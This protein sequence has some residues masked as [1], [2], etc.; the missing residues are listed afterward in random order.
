MIKKQYQLLSFFFFFL[1]LAI[2]ALK[3]QKSI[4]APLETRSVIKIAL[5]DDPLTLDPRKNSDGPTSCFLSFLSEGL[6]KRDERGELTLSLAESVSISPDFKEYIFTLKEA[7]WSNGEPISSFQIL[8]SWKEALDQ[9][10]KAYNPEYFFGIKNARAFFEGKVEFD[11]VGIK[12]PSS[13]KFEV[14]LEEPDPHFLDLLTHRSFYPIYKDENQYFFKE[15]FVCSGPFKIEKWSPKNIITLSK[16][17]LYFDAASVRLDQIECHIVPHEHTQMSLFQTKELDW[18]GSPFS[19]LILDVHDQI[20]WGKQIHKVGSFSL[21]FFAFNQEVFPLQHLKIRKALAL[22]IDRKELADHLFQGKE[23]PALRILPLKMI[24]NDE[25]KIQDGDV[26][27]AKELF[28]QGLTELKLTRKTFPKISLSYSSSQSKHLLAQ[29]IQQ[30]WQKILGVDI[31]LQPQENQMF[32]QAFYKRN[33][34][35]AA[36]S[37]STFQKNP[38]FFLSFFKTSTALGKSLSWR[39]ESFDDLLNLASLTIHPSSREIILEKAEEFLISEMPI[40]PLFFPSQIFI[41]NPKLKGVIVHEVGGV[42]FRKAYL[43]K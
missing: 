8:N 6:T 1:F 29:A 12:A 35:I 10:F 43:E 36:V 20:K 26:V 34:Q 22:C 21:V 23:N 19:S 7:C 32:H 2:L 4:L 38:L 16:N 5:I 28:E 30:Q 17:E 15:E 11:Q 41:K 13:K 42:D 31:I 25:K 24:K 33:Y 27:K 3:K 39:G 14:V 40:A 37:R 9:N 18:I